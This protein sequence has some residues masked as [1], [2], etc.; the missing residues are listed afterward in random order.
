MLWHAIWTANRYVVF[1]LNDVCP[2]ERSIPYEIAPQNNSAACE[3]IIES[4]NDNYYMNISGIVSRNNVFMFFFLISIS[5]MGGDLG[6][7]VPKFG[8]FIDC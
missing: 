4:K 2:A 5:F 8:Q 3:P 7:L 6:K 1:R